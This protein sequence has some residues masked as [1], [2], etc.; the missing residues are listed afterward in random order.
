MIRERMLQLEQTLERLFGGR[1][2]REPLEVRRAVIESLVSQVQPVGRGRRVLPFNQ[3]TVHVVSTEATERRVMKEALEPE[4]LTRELLRGV[5]RAGAQAPA[6][7]TLAVRFVR[8]PGKGWTPG[9]RFHVTVSQSAG[10]QSTSSGAPAEELP[11]ESEAG[12]STAASGP[13]SIVLRVLEGEA[14]PKTLT[15][16]AVRVTIGRQTEVVDQTGRP[17]RRNDVAFVGEDEVSRSVSRAHAHIAIDRAAGVYRVFDENS[18]HGTQVERE[19]RRITVPAGRDGL[20]LR[21][22]DEIHVGRAILRFEL[23]PAKQA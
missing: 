9:S 6:G 4:D 19:G 7:F 14:R 1:P 20:K 15:S 10:P 12:T 21:A 8:E 3:A 23:K 5:E 2:P 11:T 13:G 17:V 22:G 18:A 16:D